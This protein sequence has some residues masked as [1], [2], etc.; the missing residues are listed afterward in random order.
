MIRNK[1]GLINA[2]SHLPSIGERY[3][4][5][6][7]TWAQNRE[8]M[9]NHVEKDDIDSFLRWS[10]ITAT[11]FAKEEAYLDK[12]YKALMEDDTA[13]WMKAI[14]ESHVGNPHM[15][16]GNR[17]ASGSLIHQ[18]YHLMQMEKHT[19]STVDK[20]D[21]IVEFGA[22]YGSMCAITRRL[23]FKG[24]YH[25][26]DLPEFSLIQEYY[27]YQLGLSKDAYFYEI[28]DLG[29]FPPPPLLTNWLVGC[30]SLSEVDSGLRNTF[31]S[32]TKAEHVMMVMA[33]FW[34]TKETFTVE[35][36][37][38]QKANKNYEWANYISDAEES[39]SYVIGV[40]SDN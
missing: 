16:S 12:E 40:R 39:F 30:F 17:K 18:A 36:G 3:K 27:L 11:M 4:K 10:T 29:R 38:F 8:S 1:Q 6:N 35:Y 34:F 26:Y 21:R 13:R 24:A 9:R 32:A 7:E 19:G 14:T 31:V 33:Q 2:Y 15:Y 25:M 28:D 23:G 5:K 20:L 22:G 37:A